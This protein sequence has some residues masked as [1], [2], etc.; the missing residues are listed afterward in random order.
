MNA[1]IRLKL[2]MAT[3]VYRFLLAHPSDDPGYLGLVTRL[4]DRIDRGEFLAEQE[5]AGHLT[6]HASVASKDE[7]KD[8][9]REH[10]LVLARVADLAALDQPGLDERLTP[11][12][13]GVSHKAFLTASRV[14]LGQVGAQRDLF[15]QHGMPATLLEELA[16]LVD[17]YEGAVNEKNAAASAHV[18]ANADLEAVAGDILRVVQLLDRLNRVRFRKNGELL[19]AWKS[20]R[21]VAWPHDRTDGGQPSDGAAEPAA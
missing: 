15:L 20:A 5:R 2:E 13:M 18:G 4:K 14:A 6:V 8:I 3:R 1:D 7:L 21:D 11:P 9:I 16:A 17:Q 19:A 12:A 10:L